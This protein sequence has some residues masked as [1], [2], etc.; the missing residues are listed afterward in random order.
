MRRRRPDDAPSPPDARS[1]SPRRSSVAFE[2]TTNHTAK[3]TA[4]ILAS[5]HGAALAAE[6]GSANGGKLTK[7]ALERSPSPPS[8]EFAERAANA[9]KAWDESD[10]D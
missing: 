2:A 1:P 3:T 4:L 7:K 8:E 10:S 5:S 6:L 9:E